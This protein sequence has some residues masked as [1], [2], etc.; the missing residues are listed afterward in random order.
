MLMVSRWHRA[1]PLQLAPLH[2]RLLSPPRRAASMGM[3]VYS[4][5]PMWMCC[6]DTWDAPPLSGNHRL[7]FGGITSP[8]TGFSMLARSPCDFGRR[9]ECPWHHVQ[10]G[11]MSR[12]SWLGVPVRLNLFGSQRHHAARPPWRQR[13]AVGA[14]TGGH[15]AIARS[16]APARY[17]VLDS[18]FP[19]RESSEGAPRFPPWTTNLPPIVSGPGRRVLPV[20]W[21][22]FLPSKPVSTPVGQNSRASATGACVM[23]I[24]RA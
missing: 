13:S 6:R 24:G 21:R 3:A 9:A 10:Q 16:S 7:V 19:L 14:L 23:P 18:R 8:R 22:S 20:P 11:R 2:H 5:Q 15:D 4:R 12:R 1:A 17:C